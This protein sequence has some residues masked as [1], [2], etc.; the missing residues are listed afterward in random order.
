MIAVTIPSFYFVVILKDYENMAKS[1][2][3]RWTKTWQ[4]WPFAYWERMQE[5]GHGSS[6]PLI[7]FLA[8]EKQLTCTMD[9]VSAIQLF[10]LWVC[11]PAKME[12]CAR[13]KPLARRNVSA[14]KFPV[15]EK[16][17]KDQTF[18]ASCKSRI[19]RAFIDVMC[20]VWFELHGGRCWIQS[21]VWGMLGWY[22][23][24]VEALEN[25][26]NMTQYSR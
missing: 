3:V 11:I 15:A 17:W 25:L 13:G 14:S 26:V 12:V 4:A 23:S 9:L 20:H 19:L 16:K 1:K 10:F 21:M 8:T 18:L 22:V 24:K 7:A 2:L 6:V 5:Y